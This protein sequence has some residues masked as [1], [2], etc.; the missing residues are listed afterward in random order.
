MQNFQAGQ[1]RQASLRLKG[2][3]FLLVTA[4]GWGSNW[5]AIK[6]LLR[7]WPPL[8]SRGV[9]GVIAACI[10]LPIALRY[11]EK[12]SF[13]RS[14]LPRLLFSSFTNVF[15]WMGFSTLAMKSLNVSEAAILVYT[16][17][18]WAIMLAWPI[19]GARP[20]QRGIAAVV[21][22]FI[23]V[24]VLLGGSTFSAGSG[25]ITGIM[26]S[27]AAAILFALGSI[28]NRT[29]LPIPPLAA[30][31]W[32]VGLGCVPMVIL[33]LL[34]E[35]PKFEALTAGGFAVL[36]YMALV[37]MC[38]CYLSWFATLRYLPAQ[39]ASTG[40]LL[41]PVVGIVSAALLLGEPLGWKEVLSTAITLSGVTLALRQN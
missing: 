24:A 13:P 33:G 39:T 29:P 41:V 8:F 38:I 28:L 31:M 19:L 12:L 34:W 15:A 35:H 2:I 25:E 37:S 21:L 26:L 40:M 3:L 11:G 9:A 22:G 1:R 23:G 17:P 5:T 27:L 7:E 16:M 30:V 4:F 32:Q 10:L 36:I 14:A 6:I 20:N 18:I